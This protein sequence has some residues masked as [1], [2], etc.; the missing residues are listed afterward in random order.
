MLAA[1]LSPTP[2]SEGAPPLLASQNLDLA[3]PLFQDKTFTTVQVYVTCCQPDLGSNIS[4]P[5]SCSV[6]TALW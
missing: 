3:N 5:Q 1:W 2:Y 6:Q 4:S